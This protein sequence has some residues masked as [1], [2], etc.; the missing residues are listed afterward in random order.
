MTDLEPRPIEPASRGWMI[1]VIGNPESVGGAIEPR[2]V[3]PSDGV[4]RCQIVLTPGR[5]YRRMGV[6]TIWHR[7]TPSDGGTARGS[8]APPTD[9]GFPITLIIQPRLAG[10][11]GRGSRSV[12]AAAPPSQSDREG[13]I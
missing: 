8:M 11:I 7:S 3:P 4:D 13:S 10:S 5:L 2:A 6:R 1:S 9:S 12:M